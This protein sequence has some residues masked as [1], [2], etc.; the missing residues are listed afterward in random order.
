MSTIPH[1]RAQTTPLPSTPDLDE[2]M[3]G[4]RST[5][6]WLKQ[7]DGFVAAGEAARFEQGPLPATAASRSSRFALASTWWKEILSAAEIRTDVASPGAGMLCIGSFSFEPHSPA[8]STLIVPQVVVGRHA[9][10]AF[11][12]LVGPS[13]RDVFDTLSPAARELLDAVLKGVN[14]SYATHGAAQVTPAPGSTPSARYQRAFDALKDRICA[15]DVSKVVLAREVTIETEDTIDER[16]LVSRLS[17]AYP[18]CWTFA[19]D[20]LIGATPELLAATSHSTVTTRVLAGTLPRTGNEDGARLQNSAKDRHEHRLAVD[21]VVTALSKLGTTVADD[22]PFLL[23]LPN[24]LHL[25]TDVRTDLSFDANAL[26]VTGALHPTAALG[27]TPTHAALDLIGEHEGIDRDRYGAPVGWMDS[28]GHG[29]WCVALRCLR[30]DDE[31]HARAWVGGGIVADS[32]MASEYA[33]TEAK[34]APVLHALG[35][36]C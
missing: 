2:I 29:Q 6:A 12:T 34:L 31:T 4:A 1:L 19:V 30:V 20:G 24:V 28:T 5:L 8:G 16:T 26:Q 27:G 35:I 13:D 15:G 11:L 7:G 23:E 33:E 22:E 10:Q 14:P 25:A 3:V 21:S 36:S 17:A 32:N 18:D 9:G